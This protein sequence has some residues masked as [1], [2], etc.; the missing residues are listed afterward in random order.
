MNEEEQEKFVELFEIV[1]NLKTIKCRLTHERVQIDKTSKLPVVRHVSEPV[2]DR[3]GLCP[4]ETRSERV[5]CGHTTAHV[6]MLEAIRMLEAEGNFDRELWSDFDRILNQI[7]QLDHKKGFAESDLAVLIEKQ[8]NQP[9]KYLEIERVDAEN[10]IKE[11]ED[12]HD[13]YVEGI[14]K[15]RDRVISEMQKVIDTF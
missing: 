2:Y 13:K 5:S 1:R 10:A 7:Y 12:Q 4:H 9:N 8:V 14:G 6:P 11:I 15:V 3:I